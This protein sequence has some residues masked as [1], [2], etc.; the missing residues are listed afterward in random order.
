LFNETLDLLHFIQT[1]VRYESI[2]QDACI[3]SPQPDN[4]DPGEDDLEPLVVTE[5]KCEFI[6]IISFPVT[7][8]EL[9]CNT[10]T[11]DP[12]SKIKKRKTNVP[13]GQGQ[14]SKKRNRGRSGGPLR[15]TSGGPS[16][17]FI[18]ELD[19][20]GNINKKTAPLN[21]EDKDLSQFSIEYD[22]WG[23]LVG[24]NFQLNEDGTALADPDSQD[25]GMD[26]RWS[27]NAIGSPVKGFLNKLL[28]KRQ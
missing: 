20:P 3:N 13:K 12:N 6:K 4:T 21:A 16:S 22:K 18:Y 9:K 11:Y 25:T 23:N 2:V 8:F 10:I 27:W 1:L 7:H 24:L 19:E 28:I 14:S 15:A 26:S 5:V 17:F